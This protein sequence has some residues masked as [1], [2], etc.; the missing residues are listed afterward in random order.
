M[1]DFKKLA[2]DADSELEALLASRKAGI[3]GVT[4]RNIAESSAGRGDMVTGGLQGIASEFNLS[5]DVVASGNVQGGQ[6][7]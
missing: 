2:L 1:I 4:D 6:V 7:G 5:P 3:S